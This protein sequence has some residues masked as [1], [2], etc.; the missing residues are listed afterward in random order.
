VTQKKLRSWLTGQVV[1]V[2]AGGGGV[3]ASSP[4]SLLTSIRRAWPPGPAAA[5]LTPPCKRGVNG[6][7]PEVFRGGLWVGEEA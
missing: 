2:T 5:I 7:Y 4:S 6:M 3:A 1:R